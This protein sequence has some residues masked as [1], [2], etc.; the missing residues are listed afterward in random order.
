MKVLGY[1][2]SLGFNWCLS[3]CLKKVWLFVLNMC[4]YSVEMQLPH[5]Q[6][7]RLPTEQSSLETSPVLLCCV[8]GKD[9][10]HL[11]YLCESLPRINSMGTGKFTVGVE[12]GG[13]SQW[14]PSIPSRERNTPCHVML[15]PEIY[16]L[17]WSATLLIH[18][19]WL[20]K[21]FEQLHQIIYSNPCLPCKQGFS[22]LG[23][24]AAF[25]WTLFKNIVLF[26][27]CCFINC[28]FE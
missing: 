22:Q 23:I 21:S 25:G 11:Q 18:V 27:R 4:S 7:A 26:F 6:C 28:S 10:L 1:I 12:G 9:S 19:C 8:L 17:A 3:G 15:K 2:S 20:K 13:V 5:G 16:T 14:W 24:Q